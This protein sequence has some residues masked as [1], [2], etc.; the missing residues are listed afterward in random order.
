MSRGPIDLQQMAAQKQMQEVQKLSNMYSMAASLVNV[1]FVEVIKG[2]LN[3][4]ELADRSLC[5]AK[6]FFDVIDR[7]SEQ[8]KKENEDKLKL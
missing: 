5:Q 3:A 6:T 2:T 8:R 1:G 7:D 4:E